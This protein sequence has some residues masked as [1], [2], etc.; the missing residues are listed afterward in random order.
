MDAEF[1]FPWPDDVD[2]LVLAGG[3]GNGSGL[4]PGRRSYPTCTSDVI[5]ILAE[6]G[7]KA[8]YA[9]PVD[10]RA[11]VSAKAAEFW[12]PVLLFTREAL[13]SGAGNLLSAA[14]TELIG[15]RGIKRSELRLKVGESET[16]QGNSRWFEGEGNAEDV[17]QSFGKW[18]EGTTDGSHRK[19]R[20]R[21]TNIR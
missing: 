6:G 19:T 8:S 12:C 2:V 1:S 17:I 18:I 11:T 15:A 14:I 5:K 13:A 3:P 7:V 9:E 21:K 20:D 10:S 4:G 16:R